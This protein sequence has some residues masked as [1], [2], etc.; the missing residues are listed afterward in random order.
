M[1]LRIWAWVFDTVP[2]AKTTFILAFVALFWLF[3]IMVGISIA[4]GDV[5]T[6]GHDVPSCE[7]DELVVGIDSFDNGYW[8]EYI[9]VHPDVIFNG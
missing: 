2:S 8:S 6:R 9:C 3:V 4:K 1:I 5:D 7:E